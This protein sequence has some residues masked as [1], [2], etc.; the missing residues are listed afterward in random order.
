MTTESASPVSDPGGSTAVDGA[1]P[2]GRHECQ[3][4]TV[5]FGGLVALNDVELAVSPSKI[6]GLVGP[7]G[8]GKST[9][10]GVLS[11]LLR[12]ARGKVLLKLNVAG[13]ELDQVIALLPSLKSPTVSELF[14][15]TGFAVESVV[16]KADVNVLIPALKDNG[17]TDIIELAL[18]KIVH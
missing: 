12:P 6:V 11:G 2:R 7:N 14:G 1:A 3:D 4:V 8:A 13:P 10:F 17:A 18:A 5:H 16:A 9:L 15:G